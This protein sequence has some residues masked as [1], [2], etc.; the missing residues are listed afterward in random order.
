[1]VRLPEGAVVLARSPG[2]EVQV[3][4][5]GP[6]AW[7]IQAHPEVDTEVVRRWAASDRDDHVALG[8]DQDAV[9]AAIQDAEPA[10]V[11]HWRP[12]AARFAALAGEDRG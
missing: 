8:L 2:G 9:L 12:M 11:S 5:F 6:R 4:R 3:A 1:M 10:L 7:G